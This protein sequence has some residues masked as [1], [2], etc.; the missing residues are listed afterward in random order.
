[1]RKPRFTEWQGTVAKVMS[2]AKKWSAGSFQP[3]MRQA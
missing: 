2:G 1:M 3:R